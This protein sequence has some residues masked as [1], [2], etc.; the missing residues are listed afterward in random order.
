MPKP[1]SGTLH[2]S[3]P[4]IPQNGV[5]VFDHLPGGRLRFSYDQSIWH[6]TIVRNP[7]G[8]QKLILRSSSPGS[9]TECVV[10]WQQIP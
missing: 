2:Y 8:T 7:D 10:Q 4:P 5:V 1:Q 9:Q 3:G 6:P